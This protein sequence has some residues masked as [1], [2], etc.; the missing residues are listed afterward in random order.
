M[1]MKIRYIVKLCALALFTPVAL[2]SQLYKMQA[3]SIAADST[4]M[5]TLTYVEFAKLMVPG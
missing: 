4:D 3:V 2:I 5:A 1:N